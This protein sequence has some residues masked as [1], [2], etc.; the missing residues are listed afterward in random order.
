MSDSN[1]HDGSDFYREYNLVQSRSTIT[2]KE[3]AAH[4]NAAL[5]KLRSWYSSSSAEPQGAILVLPTGAGKTFTAGHFTCRDPLSHGFKVLWLAHSHHLL[6]QALDCFDGL[7]PLILEPKSRLA[8]RVVSGASEHF[9]VHSILATDDVVVASLQVISKAMIKEHESLNR[10]LQSANGKLF[11]IFDEA[12]HSPAPTYRRLLQHLRERCPEMRLLGLTATPTY[13]N[14]K[15]RG[16]LLKLFPQGIVHQ[17]TPQELMAADV[18]AKP[19]IEEARTSIKPEFSDQQYA[20]WVGTNRDIPEDT[21]LY[22][23]ENRTRNEYIAGYYL[24]H[25]ER[26]G[27]TLIFADR[28][29]QCETICTLL[30]SRGVRADAVY[31]RVAS[32]SGTPED[33]NR[34]TPSENAKTLQKFRDGELDVLINIQMLTEGTDV[35]DVNTVFLTR[36]TTSSILLTQMI[37]RAL[38]GPKFGGTEKAY[39]VSFIDDWKQ[40]I[41]WA[42]YEPI[43]GQAIDGSAQEYGKR[44][45]IQLLS[46][47]L[48]RRLARQMDSGINMNPAPFRSFLP[49]GWFRVE[50]DAQV[51][52][53]DDVEDIEPVRQLIL[54][55]EQE[56][57][58]FDGFINAIKGEN[59][60]DFE[61]SSVQLDDVRSRLEGWE[62][63]FF[64]E[65]A[66]RLGLT[67]V[68][69]MFSIVRHMAQNDNEPPT[70]FPFESRKEHDLDS[71]AGNFIKQGLS[72][73]AI[74]Q[75]LKVEFGRQDRFWGAIYPSYQLFKSHYDACNNRI[76]E[77]LEHKS[78]PDDYR[79]HEYVRPEAIPDREPSEELKQQVK[80]RDQY[81]CLCCGCTE[82]R[83]LQ[84]DHIASSYTGG[85]NHLDNLQT[86]CKMCNVAK[87]TDTIRFRINQTPLRTSPSQVFPLRPPTG[88]RVKVPKQWEMCIRRWVNLNYQCAAAH[89]VEVGEK[90][91]RL[92]VWA[93]R[94]FPGNDPKWLTPH[95]AALVSLIRETRQEAGYTAAP[96]RI[97]INEPKPIVEPQV[98]EE[99]LTALDDV[100]RKIEE[101][102]GFRVCISNHDGRKVR[103]DWAKDIQPYPYKY[104]WNGAKTVSAW[105]NSRFFKNYPVISDQGFQ[106][107]LI[108]GSGNRCAGQS[109]LK[110]V[111]ESYSN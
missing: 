70:F 109:K 15:K 40:R 11:V 104:A 55:Y 5:V 26:F 63:R 29:T 51:Q 23:A 61:E 84:V 111:R 18:L 81:R 92:R 37:G 64:T 90:G 91:E 28:W 43:T 89:E 35:P 60:H 44:P 49:L 38:R 105:K 88:D 96:D 77:A 36:Q 7:V 110:T 32:T 76:L 95:I 6:K 75:S 56:K 83:W 14:E 78:D 85:K 54:V 69:D 47:D 39:I 46:I 31:S 71:V 65:A 86:L 94:L 22:L 101:I 66:H 99:N 62:G 9:P 108:D 106:V 82:K 12:H 74:S 48:I 80:S 57:P 41:H 93:I 3:P 13:T 8:I 4:Q 59:L 72:P 45:P 27:K 79:P 16:W 103:G 10:F 19:V 107:D 102:E 67:L 17:E 30:A 50:F 87:G 58:Q 97:T 33:R 1:R 24:K 98:R 25:R 42:A 100:L 68:N 2:T 20:K 53:K 34:R 21:I 73:T 52:G